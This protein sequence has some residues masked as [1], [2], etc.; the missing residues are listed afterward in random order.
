[1]ICELSRNMATQYAYFYIDSADETANLPTME[2]SGESGKTLFNT[3]VAG[4]MASCKDGTR[5]V[6]T[7]EN[8]WEV[9]T[10]SG[11][12]GSGGGDATIH[13]AITDDEIA[14]LFD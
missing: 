7:G 10:G 5:Y 9:F 11:G 13:Q 3:C 4:S 12:G 2:K 1:M 8:T 14:A 6:L